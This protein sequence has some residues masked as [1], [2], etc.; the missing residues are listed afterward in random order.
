MIK[1]Q[2][3]FGH[4]L[5]I[6]IYIFFQITMNVLLALITVML[7]Q[8]VRIRLDHLLALAMLDTLA[9]DWCVQVYAHIH[10]VVVVLVAVV[11][12]V[13]IIVVVFNKN[14]LSYE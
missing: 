3:E 13:L 12:L 7:M 9:V 4:L 11:V 10:L 14:G 5:Y 1:V 6:H 8:H 2:L